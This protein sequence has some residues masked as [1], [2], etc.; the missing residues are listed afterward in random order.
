LQQY[1]QACFGQYL[2]CGQNLAAGAVWGEAVILLILAVV[3]FDFCKYESKIRKYYFGT[4]KNLF[5]PLIFTNF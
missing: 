3:Q 5:C 1:R 4:S 2:Y